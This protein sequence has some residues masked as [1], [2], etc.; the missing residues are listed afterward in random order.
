MAVAIIGT[1]LIISLVVVI[2][3][4]HLLKKKTD[5]RELKQKNLLLL[6]ELQE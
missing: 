5:R 3:S 6:A 2:G 4:I 1:L